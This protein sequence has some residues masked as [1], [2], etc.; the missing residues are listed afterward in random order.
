MI[1]P[2]TCPICKKVV[3]VK[4]S[5][6]QSPFPFCSKKC[7][8]VDLFRWSEGKYAIVEDLDPRLIELQRLEQEDEDY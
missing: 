7:R 8:D 1:Q 2:Q 3:T 5:D 6:E 4:A